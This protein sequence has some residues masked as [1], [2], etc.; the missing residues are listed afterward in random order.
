[1]RRSDRK[2]QDGGAVACGQ[3]QGRV[4]PPG[5]P[6]KAA[7]SSVQPATRTDVEPAAPASLLDEFCIDTD[8]L[9]AVARRQ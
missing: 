1:M 5:E 3:G 2:E 7:A 8:D 9:R 6:S 4:S